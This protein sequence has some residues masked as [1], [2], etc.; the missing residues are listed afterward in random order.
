MKE[1]TDDEKI[2]ARNIDKLYRWIARDKTGRLGVFSDK[3]YKDHNSW[4]IRGCTLDMNVFCQEFHSIRWD[5]EEP[6]LI[7]DIYEPQILDD[8]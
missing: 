5:D 4:N 2:I 8:A 6:T 7:K 1:F 3:P